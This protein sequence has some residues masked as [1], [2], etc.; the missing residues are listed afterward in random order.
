[1]KAMRE[2]WPN[3]PI[4]QAHKQGKD[5][6]IVA[7]GPAV[8]DALKA[9]DILAAENKISVEV[10]D[11]RSL[12]PLDVETIVASVEAELLVMVPVPAMAPTVWVVPLRSTVPAETVRRPVVNLPEPVIWRVPVPNL[13]TPLVDVLRLLPRVKTLAPL[14]M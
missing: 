4:N 12:V 5:L 9:A 7:W 1:M 10:V 2:A 8:H 13:V 3:F 6:T 11:I 14:L